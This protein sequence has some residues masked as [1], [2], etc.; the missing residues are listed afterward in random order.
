M[1]KRLIIFLTSIFLIG[2]TIY[3]NYDRLYET[4]Y[5][6]TDGLVEFTVEGD[7]AYMEGVISYRTIAR[8]EELIDEHPQVT[9]IVMVEVPGSVDDE[10]NLIASRL[11]RQAGL[12]T[13]VPEG[14]Y[15]ASGGVDFFCAGVERTAHKNSTFGVHSWSWGGDT[16]ADEL[17]KTDPEHE[18]YLAY[19]REMGIDEEFYWFTIEAAPAD[20]MYDMTYE[21]LIAYGLIQ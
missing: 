5:D 6:V 8:V 10:A 13:N 18:V 17:P 16:S 21:E 9:T 1:G 14:G 12:N 2:A 15:I 3:G 4:Y 11:V 7:K 20:D 19:F